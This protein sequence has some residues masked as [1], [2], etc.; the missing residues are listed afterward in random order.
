M[1][2]LVGDADLNDVVDFADIPAFIAVLQGGTFL[3]EAD[4]NRDGMVDFSDI[5]GFIAVLSAQ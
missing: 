1:M 3:D 4:I 2:P 5:P